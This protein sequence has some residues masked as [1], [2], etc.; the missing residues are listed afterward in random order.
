MSRLV[1]VLGYGAEELAGEKACERKQRER[2]REAP[3]FGKADTYSIDGLPRQSSFIPVSAV[4][5]WQFRIG[6]KAGFISIVIR[7]TA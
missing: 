1:G 6:R 2:D 4:Y 5:S 3:V 7:N